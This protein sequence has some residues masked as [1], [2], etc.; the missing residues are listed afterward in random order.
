MKMYNTGNQLPFNAHGLSTQ[1]VRF[2]PNNPPGQGGNFNIPQTLQYIVPFAAAS[3]A[4]DVTDKANN[5]SGRVFLFNQVTSNNYC[6]QAYQAGVALTLDFLCLGLVK[7]NYRQPEEG[8]QDAAAKASSMLSAGNYQ[9]FPAL[10]QYVSPEIVN[11]ASQLY[12]ALPQLQQDFVIVKNQLNNSGMQRNNQFVQHNN[13]G[14]NNNR[15]SVQLNQGPHSQGTGMF[16]GGSVVNVNQTFNTDPIDQKYSYLS[17][18]PAQHQQPSKTQQVMVEDNIPDAI[19]VPTLA[20]PSP[21]AP[22]PSKNKVS[23]IQ[24]LEVNQTK[25][26]EYVLED[27]T[28]KEM[29]R[30][31]HVIGPLWEGYAQETLVEC[32]VKDRAIE[33]RN[34]VKRLTYDENYRS[35]TTAELKAQVANSTGLSAHEFNE[36]LPPFEDIPFISSNFLEDAIFQVR[37]KGPAVYRSLAPGIHREKVLLASPFINRT[38][39]PG[40]KSVFGEIVPLLTYYHTFEDIINCMKEVFDV[41]RPYSILFLPVIDKLFTE[42]INS[43]LVNKMSANTKIDSFFTDILDL[44]PFI[45]NRY[46]ETFAKALKSVE[47]SF[48]SKYLSGYFGSVELRDMF[49]DNLADEGSEACIDYVPQNLTIT[50]LSMHSKELDFSLVS[51]VGTSLSEKNNPVMYAIADG[52][53]R[54]EHYSKTDFAHHLVV[55]IDDVIFEVHKGLIGHNFLVS[56]YK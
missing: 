45:E 6:N 26:A 20:Q 44:V 23:L 49:H 55:T 53:F 39:K 29:E 27:L 48:T 54:F 1:Q 4:N 32:E 19:W 37:M 47:T 42:E 9:Q 2:A 50:T 14:F 46:G 21:I 33:F 18:N 52:I 56:K 43:V 36:G 28:E 51:D 41:N 10:Q 8:L 5:N 3:F 31:A 34:N 40:Q 35:K 25:R 24:V 13:Q 22:N 16:S 12:N 30:N 17:T 7:G 11:G 38:L 15:A